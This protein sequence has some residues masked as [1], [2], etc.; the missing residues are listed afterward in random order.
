MT[1]DGGEELIGEYGLKDCGM[2][3]FTPLVGKPEPTK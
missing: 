3:L 2:P 1:S